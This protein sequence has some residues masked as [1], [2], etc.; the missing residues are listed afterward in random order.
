MFLSIPAGF[1]GTGSHPI[2]FVTAGLPDWQLAG[3]LPG[4]Q[5]LPL[6]GGSGSLASLCRSQAIP[7]TTSLGSIVMR[8]SWEETCRMQPWALAG[9]GHRQEPNTGGSAIL[10]YQV[11]MVSPPPGL[12]CRFGLKKIPWQRCSC[13]CQETDSQPGWQIIYDGQQDPSV[14]QPGSRSCCS[15]LA[16]S[17]SPPT[18]CADSLCQVWCCKTCPTGQLTST[19][20]GALR[21]RTQ[22]HGL[23]PCRSRALMIVITQQ[24][25]IPSR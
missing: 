1:D 24:A 17:C 22:I 14:K 7:E 5:L 9:S 11:E 13:T 12:T 21:V 10:G 15:L 6:L 23:R 16:G 18:A 25:W 3:Y 8:L 20:C 2:S 19:T 4:N